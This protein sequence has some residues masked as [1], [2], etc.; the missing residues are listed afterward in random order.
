V[1]L[2][3]LGRFFHPWMCHSA[4]MCN[5]T[6]YRMARPTT[7]VREQEWLLY[8]L[9]NREEK[10]SATETAN[11]GY[12]ERDWVQDAYLAAWSQRFV[13]QRENVPWVDLTE[14]GC[15]GQGEGIF[16]LCG[17]SRPRDES[18]LFRQKEPKPCLPVRGPSEPAQKPA[19]RDASASVPN[20]DGSGTRSAQT[21][22]AERPIRDSGSAAPNAVKCKYL[23][24]KYFE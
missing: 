2:A 11:W 23:D 16:I 6:C 20:Q 3:G 12:P 15:Q 13:D 5:R 22:L 10:R 1:S 21:A 17:L 7:V 8:N 18:L 4:R 24:N 9:G 19:L 14:R